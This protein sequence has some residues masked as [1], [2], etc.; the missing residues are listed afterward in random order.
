MVLDG[1]ASARVTPGPKEHRFAD[2]DALSGKKPGP[3]PKLHRSGARPDSEGEPLAKTLS[4]SEL[5]KKDSA[6]HVDS[7]PHEGHEAG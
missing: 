1:I 6:E 5:T 7:E 2:D 3:V 4:F